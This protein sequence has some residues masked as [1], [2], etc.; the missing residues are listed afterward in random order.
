M[1]MGI[2]TDIGVYFS[3]FWFFSMQQL[4]NMSDYI[5]PLLLHLH[6]ADLG[7][8]AFFLFCVLPRCNDFDIILFLFCFV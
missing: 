8:D 7:M 2:S 4:Y 5:P 3:F 6:T 1:G